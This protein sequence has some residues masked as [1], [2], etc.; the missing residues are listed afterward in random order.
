MKCVLGSL[1]KNLSVVWIGQAAGH[2]N[3]QVEFSSH[4]Q[5]ISVEHPLWFQRHVQSNHRK[6]L[7]DMREKVLEKWRQECVRATQA[8]R[9]LGECAC[10]PWPKTLLLASSLLY[11]VLQCE[12]AG[13]RS[14]RRGQADSIQTG[15]SPE[16]RMEHRC[17][18]WSLGLDS[19][20]VNVTYLRSVSNQRLRLMCLTSLQKNQ[21]RLFALT[22]VRDAMYRT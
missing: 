3:L 18:W 6:V 19:C 13:T 20:L 22:S 16:S 4:T 10:L 9:R 12:S 11:G 21:N 14:R 1:S 2:Q 7:H 17:R 8:L 5:T 15:L